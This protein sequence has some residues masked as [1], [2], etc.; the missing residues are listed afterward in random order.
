MGLLSTNTGSS[1]LKVARRY[2]NRAS[3]SSVSLYK[4]FWKASIL[5]KPLAEGTLPSVSIGMVGSR[6]VVLT[7]VTYPL[8]LLQRPKKKP[9]V[10]I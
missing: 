6:R 4:V 8:T 1:K 10:S 3:C 5:G 9:F 2:P 7:L